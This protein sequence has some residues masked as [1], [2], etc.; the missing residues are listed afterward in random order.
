MVRALATFWRKAYEDNLT[1]MAAMVAYNLILSVVPARARRRCSWPGGSWRPRTSRRRSSRT[2][3]GCSPPRPSR[4]WSTAC[5]ACASP[6]RPSGSSRSWRRPGSRPRSGARSTPRSAASTTASA[7]R[8]CGRSCSAS[9]CSRS[10]SCSSSR[11]S[12]SRRCRASCVRGTRG[13]AVRAR[14]TCAALVYGVSLAG[15]LA[16]LFGD[17]VPRL[18]ARA[19]RPDPVALRLARRRRRAGRDGGRGLRA[20]RSTSRTSRRCGSARRSCS[21]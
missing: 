3:S 15:G 2:S 13:P 4:R 7:A 5:G 8:G 19:A 12:A 18:L 10:C 1:G 6:R 17:P 21:S 9:G 20:S 11:A 16:L 14:A